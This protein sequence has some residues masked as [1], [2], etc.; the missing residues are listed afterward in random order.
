MTTGERMKRRRKEYNIPVEAIAEILNVSIA[1]VYRYE[2]GEIEKVPGALLEPLA[3]VLRTTPAYLMGWESFEEADIFSISNIVPI[4]TKKIPLLG[5]I[6]AGQPI[7][8]EEGFECYVECGADVKADF[9]LRIKGNSMINA[10][11]ND[12]DL[13]FIRKQETVNHGEIAAVLIDDEAT[14]KRWRQYGNR[15][16]LHAENPDYP[17][18][19]YDLGEN[20]VSIIGKAVAFQS[21][22][23]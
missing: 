10:R 19:E 2:S 7:F 3:K 12:G 20:N 18:F 9:A 11:I 1:T 17:D 15:V 13:V 4:E 21:D 16:V 5:T 23:R 6:A 14:L 22:V 8:A